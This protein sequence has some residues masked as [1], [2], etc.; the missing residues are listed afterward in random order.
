MR[1]RKERTGKKHRKC[2]RELEK[3]NESE[4]KRKK[5]REE[6]ERKKIGR[7]S[8]VY[9]GKWVLKSS[10]TDQ[11]AL[12]NNKNKKNSTHPQDFYEQ[13]DRAVRIQ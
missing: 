1:N 10:Q 9:K 7:D 8:Q 6:S 5:T 3:D 11:A 13:T 12:Q 4:R 2:E